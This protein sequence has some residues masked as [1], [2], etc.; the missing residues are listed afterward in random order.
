MRDGSNCFFM[1]LWGK[2]EERIR[3]RKEYLWRKILSGIQR[4]ADAIMKI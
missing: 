2:A 3:E 1:L 4:M